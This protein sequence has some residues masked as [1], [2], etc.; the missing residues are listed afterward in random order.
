MM[1][2]GL[3][4]IVPFV[5]GGSCGGSG[6]RS[7]KNSGSTAALRVE[8]VQ[9]VYFSGGYYL[10]VDVFV[11]ANDPMQAWDLTVGWNTVN[12]EHLGTAPAPEFDDDGAFFQSVLDPEAGTLTLVDVRHTGEISGD[13]RVAEMWLVAWYGGSANVTIQGAVA[14]GAGNPFTIVANTNGT[15]P[16]TP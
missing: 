2:L 11:G 12:L 13:L 10:K 15:F 14:D 4:A 7:G 16:I 9:V 1:A 8:P 6:S 3:L 5:Q